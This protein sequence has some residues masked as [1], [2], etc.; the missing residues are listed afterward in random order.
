[1]FVRCGMRT[2][3]GLKATASDAV[4]VHGPSQL[5][6][7]ATRLTWR[8]RQSRTSRGDPSSSDFIDDASDAS[9]V[10]TGSNTN[11]RSFD[12]YP[13]PFTSPEIVGVYGKPEKKL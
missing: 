5:F 6:R 7:A 11:A 3:T 10:C 9:A 13:S 1:M 12:A 4:D 8:V 2:F